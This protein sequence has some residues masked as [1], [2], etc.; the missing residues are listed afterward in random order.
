DCLVSPAAPVNLLFTLRGVHVARFAADKGFVHLNLAGQLPAALLHRQTDSVQHEPSGFL[1]DAQVAADLVGANAVLA[2]RNEPH[3]RKPLVK[4][5]RRILKDGSDLDG[6]LRLRMASL[7][8]P[9][10]PR[11]HKTDILGIAVRA[12]NAARP[13]IE[14]KVVQAVVRVREIDDR[15]LQGLRGDRLNGA[16]RKQYMSETLRSQL[17]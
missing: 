3:R 16:H 17:Y 6:K 4:T 9:V 8:L 13:A 15:V 12:H 5:E 7:A 10:T 2:V 11:R 14:C 1:S